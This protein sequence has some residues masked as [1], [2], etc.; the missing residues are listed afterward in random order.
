MPCGP[1]SSAPPPPAVAAY[2]PPPPGLNYVA[3]IEP[4]VSLLLV[5]TI[6]A[7]MLVPVAAVLFS[8][9]TRSIRRRP[10]FILN[11]VGIA[12]GLMSGVVN[13]FIQ[14]RRPSPSPPRRWR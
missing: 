5:G 6:G 10:V 11:V 4:S 2:A 3:A 1:P 13:G 12:L 9:S 14:V 8:F 7:S